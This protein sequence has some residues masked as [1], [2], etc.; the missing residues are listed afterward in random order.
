MHRIWAPWRK[1]YLQECHNSDCFL[2]EIFHSD[3]D[4][5]NLVLHRFDDGDY[6]LETALE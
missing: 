5:K 2:C 6:V 1:Q 3:K 4:E